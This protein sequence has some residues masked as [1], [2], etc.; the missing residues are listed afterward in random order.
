MAKNAASPPHSA[1]VPA[2]KHSATAPVLAPVIDIDVRR[3]G[4]KTLADYIE[5]YTGKLIQ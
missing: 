5:E 4:R 2:E 3:I 1:S